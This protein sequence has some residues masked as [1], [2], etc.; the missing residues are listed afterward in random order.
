VV[1]LLPGARV[2]KARPA[3][4]VSTERY[5]RERPDLIVGILTTQLPESVGLTDYVLQDWR[6]AGLRASS[7]FRLYL[8]TVSRAEAAAIGRLTP[9][10]WREVQVRVGRGLAVVTDAP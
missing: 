6:E 5:H 3:V 4:V 10:D 2:T 1:A 9:R 8:I 7:C